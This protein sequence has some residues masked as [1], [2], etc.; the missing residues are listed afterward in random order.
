MEFTQNQARTLID[1][2]VETVRHWRKTIPYLATKAGKSARF[3]LADVVGLAVT[4]EL[5]NT[6]GI[7]IATLST[8]VDTMF[9]LL[10]E[11]A[12]ALLDSAIVSV[13]AKEARLYDPRSQAVGGLPNEPVLMIPLAPFVTG[14]Q[15]HIFPTAAISNQPAFRFPPESVRRQA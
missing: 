13:T 3:S 5:V 1:V 15:R 2:P 10:A 4:K 6:F 7:N 14:I 8:R 11:S 12:P 9:R